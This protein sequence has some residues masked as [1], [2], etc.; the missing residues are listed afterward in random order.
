[1]FCSCISIYMQICIEIEMFEKV[2]QVKDEIL[3]NFIILLC[4]FPSSAIL[5]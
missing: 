5:Q 4:R 2:N 3:M 1:M